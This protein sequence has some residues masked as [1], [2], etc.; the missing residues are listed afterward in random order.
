[1]AF[2]PAW[3]NT[4]CGRCEEVVAP[5]FPDLSRRQER[6]NDEIRSCFSRDFPQQGQ[7]SAGIRTCF[8]R[9]LLRP[10]RSGV[11]TC[12]SER[13]SQQGRLIDGT[14]TCSLGLPSTAGATGR[15]HSRLLFQ[16]AFY[17]RSVRLMALVP[18][19][20]GIFHGRRD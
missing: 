16:G 13:F 15:R 9:Y 1:M 3:A 20:S 11:R 19:S 5:A 4:Y 18:A 17:G 10:W 6:L 8:S 14:R 7:L 12:L 2:A